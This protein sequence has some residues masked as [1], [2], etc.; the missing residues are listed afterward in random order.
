[1]LIDQKVKEGFE[2]IS[3]Q[4]RDPQFAKGVVSVESKVL[5]NYTCEAKVGRFRFVADEHPD[6]GG[7]GKGPTPLQ[8]F[9]AGLLF[10]EQVIFVRHCAAHG[11]QV[12]SLE[13]SVRGYF[14]RRGNYGV[15]EVDAAFNQIVVTVRIKS[16]ER[17]DRISEAIARLEKH[18]PAYNTLKKSVQVIHDVTLNGL[19]LK[20]EESKASVR[21]A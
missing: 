8:Y 11:I 10:C 17:P 7:S 15:A 1:M 21:D 16:P 18:C 3:A 5:H 4:L 14:D 19:K 9:L 2:R 6:S 20:L 12:D 13:T